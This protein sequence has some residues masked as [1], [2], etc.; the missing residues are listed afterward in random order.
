MII[1]DR[2]AAVTDQIAARTGIDDALIEKLVRRFYDKVRDD[3]LL[4]PVF[5]ERIADW[6]PHLQRMFA[7]WSSVA[8][9]TGHYSGQPMQ[10]HLPLPIDATHFDR[11]LELFRQTARETCS[12]EG[13]AHFIERAERIAESL[14][15]GIASYHRVL[16]MKGERFRREEVHAPGFLHGDGTV[17]AEGRGQKSLENL[18][19][20]K[21]AGRRGA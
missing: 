18:I 19:Q 17:R 7:F 15:L 8:L 5:Q 10:K 6:E 16:L 13:A 3:P 2:R 20:R 1:S 21:D 11:W 4:G 9:L 12:P 14:E